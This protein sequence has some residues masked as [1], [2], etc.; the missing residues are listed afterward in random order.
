MIASQSNSGNN[1]V[2]GNGN[3]QARR[4]GGADFG[5]HDV[6]YHSMAFE[7]QR[8]HDG[9]GRHSVRHAARKHA[10]ASTIHTNVSEG[11]NGHNIIEYEKRD[12]LPCSRYTYR[13][14][15]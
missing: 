5:W 1:P 9:R 8:H 2:N 7:P 14:Q 15:A 13:I 12:V 11:N 4:H 3:H 10:P 6:S